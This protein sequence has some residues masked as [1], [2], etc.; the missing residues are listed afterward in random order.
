M[1]L[2]YRIADGLLSFQSTGD[3]DH[4][5][6]LAI[7]DRAL[8]EAEVLAR[9]VGGTT[10]HLLFDLRNSQERRSPE[11]LLRISQAMEARRAVFSGH[12]AVV[13]PDAYYFGMARMFEAY[14]LPAGFTVEVFYDMPSAEKHL[15][16]IPRRPTGPAT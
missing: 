12:C 7:L 11:D 5:E 16:R 2:T 6:G 14:V 13:V 10:L 4:Y 9:G 15:A 3:F 1:G 8:A